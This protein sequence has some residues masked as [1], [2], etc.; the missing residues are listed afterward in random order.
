MT[1]PSKNGS[2]QGMT[3]TWLPSSVQEFFS[4]VNWDDRPLEPQAPEQ[5]HQATT[6]ELGLDMTVTQFFEAIAW[7][8]VRVIAAFTPVEEPMAEESTV[9][10]ITLDD[11][12]GLF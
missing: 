1:L 4:A 12:S 11:F 3:S 10:E 8:G 9:D 2:A 6:G 7:D 5:A